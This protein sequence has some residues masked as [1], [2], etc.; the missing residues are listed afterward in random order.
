[1][2]DSERGRGEGGTEIA[3]CRSQERNKYAAFFL[4]IAQLIVLPLRQRVALRTLRSARIPSDGRESER[5][6]VREREGK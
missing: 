4:N 3:T 6:R 1:M 5:E 2:T